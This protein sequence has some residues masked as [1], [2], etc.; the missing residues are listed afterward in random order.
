[1]KS[2]VIFYSR[3]GTT[4]KV[5]MEIARLLK[6]D[7]EEIIDTKNREGPIGYLLSGRDATLRKAARIKKPVKNPSSYDLVIIGTPIWAWNM[8]APVRAYLIQ[9]KG[10]IKKTAFFC[11][12]G[13]SG[14]DR[15]FSEMEM[16]LGKKPAAKLA[17]LTKEVMKGQHIQKE[18]DF[19]KAISLKILKK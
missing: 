13:G 9:A 16:I 4:K 5:A 14:D 12:M 10:R 2:L 11:T 6:A 7:T 15:A 19:L 17:L 3:T 18:K 1:M 8:S